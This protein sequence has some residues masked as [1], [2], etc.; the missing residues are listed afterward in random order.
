MLAALVV[1]L[2]SVALIC[3]GHRAVAFENLAL[4][5]R[6]AVFRRTVDPLFWMLLANT[7]RD[8][9]HGTSL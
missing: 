8:W 5:Q 2:R 6:L 9:A 1:L 4:R 7:W 3:C